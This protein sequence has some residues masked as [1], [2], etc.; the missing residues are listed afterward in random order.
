MV[1]AARNPGVGGTPLTEATRVLPSSENTIWLTEPA[2]PVAGVVWF[3]FNARLVL[4]IETRPLCLST[5][6]Q[7]AK[8]ELAELERI[9]NKAAVLYTVDR[10]AIEG[11]ELRS[12]FV[13]CHRDGELAT[14]ADG[15]ADHL[16]VSWI[17]G[18]DGKQRQ[19]VGARLKAGE[20]QG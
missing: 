8:T 5:I 19:G 14:T 1:H 4:A 9:S 10:A 2:G 15:L 3:R 12:I 13:E 18:V 20:S 6:K 17:V 7:L 11:A 16:Q